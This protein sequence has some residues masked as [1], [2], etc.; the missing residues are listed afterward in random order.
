MRPKAAAGS[1]AAFIQEHFI[2]PRGGGHLV[3]E[4]VGLNWCYR[5][6]A[7]SLQAYHATAPLTDLQFNND[8]KMTLIFYRRVR[9]TSCVAL[10]FMILGASA[11][12]QSQN[13]RNELLGKLI[14]ANDNNIP[15][16]LRTQLVQHEGSYAG[17]VFDADSVVSPI[18]TAQL[19]QTLMCAYV[20]DSSRYY[21]SPEILRRMELAAMALVD[22]QHED[23]TID[24]LTTNF[25]STPDLGFTIFPLG[26]S[27]SI[28]LKNNKL[29]YGNL[30][31]TLRE[32]LLKAGKA[33]SAGGIH[34]PNHRWVVCAALAWVNSFF[35]DAKYSKRVHQW[36]REKIDIDPDG[37]YNERS[38]AVYTPITNRSLIDVAK[39]ME[40][41]HL[42]EVL[43]KNLDLTFYLVHSNGEIVTETSNRQDK[44]LRRNMSGYYLAYNQMA[45]LD[46]DGRYAGMV[47][48]IEQTVPV[49]H[50]VYMLPVFLEDASLLRPLPSPHP[51]PTQYHKHFR[52]SDMVRIR[53]GAIDMSVITDNATFFTYF[54]GDAALEAMRLSA[55]FFGK[56]QFQSQKMEKSGDTYVLSS[57]LYGPYYQPLPKRK[58]PVDT[59]AWTKVPRT[60]RAQSEVQELHTKVHITPDKGKATV[61]I[62]VEGP[63][64][65][66]VTLELGFRSGGTFEHAIPRSDLPGTWLIKNGAYAV[67]RLGTDSI[68]IGPGMREHRWTQL[69]GALPKL[70]ADC[71]YFT[72]YAPCEFEFT[73]E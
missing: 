33:L 2:L 15:G 4:G 37:Q 72:L 69:R 46:R 67:Y 60:K 14:A 56:G 36:L 53:D 50:L 30:P 42:Y 45:L 73:I 22:L 7:A 43:R 10:L 13:D 44:Y 55:A 23:G 20:S 6:Q 12:P 35:P 54:K 19:I 66:P 28:M 48:Y 41:N 38:T 57:S 17:A 26:M 71:L 52:Y 68:K 64:N 39:R 31:A 49:E 27:Y 11:F 58:I 47:R 62:S 21:N 5:Q 29:N 32:Y 9:I 24:L 51:L 34:T 40:I 70:E 18:G 25:H 63:G 1:H 8:S 65:L 3:L 16:A 61:R 59:D